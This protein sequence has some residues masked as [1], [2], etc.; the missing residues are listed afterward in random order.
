VRPIGRACLDGHELSW[1]KRSTDG[2][3]KC[4]ISPSAGRPIVVHG[5]L[6]HIPKEE[7]YLLDKV[8]G[9]GFGYEEK[10]VLVD[11]ANGRTEAVTYVAKSTHVDDALR[12]YRW[13]KDIVISGAEAFDLSTDYIATLRSVVAIEDPNADRASQNRA[14]IP[15]AGSG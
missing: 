12:P 6:F 7:K 2:S 13:Y 15:C 14:A 3:G 9:L 8:E 5:V 10:S 4:S 1:H 11:S